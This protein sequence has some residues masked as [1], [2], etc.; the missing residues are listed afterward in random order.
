MNSKFHYRQDDMITNAIK[1]THKF[2]YAC[3][4]INIHNKPVKIYNSS[5]SIKDFINIYQDTPEKHF[6]EIVHDHFYE[7]YDIDFKI[8]TLPDQ[9]DDS[10]LE[11]FNWFENTRDDFIKHNITNIN[12]L[13]KPDWIITT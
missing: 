7:Y 6:Y 4:H 2:W 13:N 8:D 1:E 3:D 10:N 9:I 5:P 11:L 12:F